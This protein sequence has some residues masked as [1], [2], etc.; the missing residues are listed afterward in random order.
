MTYVETA[1]RARVDRRKNGAVRLFVSGGYDSQPY[2][3]MDQI[4]A[5]VPSIFAP[6]KHESRS[7]RFT[8]IPTGDVLLALLKEGFVPTEVRQ[9]GSRIEGK[10]DFTKHMIRLRQHG[11][12]PGIVGP[13][14]ELYPE[15]VLSNAHD[16]TA[17]WIMDHGAYRVR[18][19][20]GMVT[21]KSYGQVKIPH[22][23][24]VIEQV[25][26]G[27][28]RVVKTLPNIIEQANQWKAIALTAHQQVAFATAARDL[29]WDR[30]DAGN[31]TAPVEPPALL[32]AYRY[33][34]RGS[35]LWLTFNRLQENLLAGGA[36][37]DHKD[38]NGKHSRRT[39][40]AVGD[41]TNNRQLNQAL[42]TLT[43]ALAQQVA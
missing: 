33:D 26:E 11:N 13:S 28:F 19:A 17:K 9:G 41:A 36:R 40:R 39:V 2:L 20:N 23:G 32:E 29:R 15:L 42:W 1:A 7:E 6:G 10:A 21:S 4:R 30:D 25:I 31:S 14:D 37:Y 8:F 27:A 24:D 16:G 18:C 38:Q 5:E 3:S 35:D 12:Q 34:D 43:E 22:R